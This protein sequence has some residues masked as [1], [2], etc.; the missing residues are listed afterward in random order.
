MGGLIA[1]GVLAIVVLGVLGFWTYRSQRQRANAAALSIRAPNGIDEATFVEVGGI[2]QWIRIRGE[3]RRN[4]VLLVLHGGPATSYMGFTPIFQPWESSFTVVQWDRRGVGKTFGRNGRSG[5]GEMTLDRIV[6]D[7]AELAEYL[8][9]H[10]H[11]DKIVLLGHSM[12]SMIGVSMAAHRPEL[13]YAY[14]GTEQIIDMAVNE[15]VSYRIILERVRAQGN[16]KVVKQL[17]RIGPPPY[18]SVR[19]WGTKQYAAEA[20]DPGYRETALN[21]RPMIGYSPAYSLKDLLDLVRG[22]LFCMSKLYD[23]WM[24]FD[25]HRLGNRFEIPIFVIQG[26]SDVMTPTELAE[27]W[28]ATVDAPHKEMIKIERGGHLV[29]ATAP[30]AYLRELVGRVRPW[31]VR[32]K[33]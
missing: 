10:L 25:A 24:R 31:A 4:P 6:A 33:A 13:F 1:W 7:G 12:G 15:A 18:E 26:A 9:K 11:V 8:S 14:V 30:D 29:M 19:V 23:Q 22:A 28:L 27:N 16:A 17:E 2:D 32:E 20:A 3:D 21:I 5:S